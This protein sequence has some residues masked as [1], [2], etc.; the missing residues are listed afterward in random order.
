MVINFVILI[1]TFALAIF[2]ILNGPLWLI[3]KLR[4]F[5]G[6]PESPQWLTRMTIITSRAIGVA[7]IL[8]WLS[9]VSQNKINL[10][11]LLGGILAVGTILLLNGPAWLIA[12]C[13]ALAHDPQVGKRLRAGISW[14]HRILG[15]GAIIS[16]FYI[17]YRQLVE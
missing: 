5:S 16:I 15:G 6:G 1:V 10:A 3:R 13:P 12:H 9:N 4:I 14:L 8:L 11:L 17:V 2:L 7:G